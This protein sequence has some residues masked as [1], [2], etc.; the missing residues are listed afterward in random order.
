MLLLGLVSMVT[1][2]PGGVLLI[3]IGG[4][5]VIC[6]SERAENYM[7]IKRQNFTRLDSAMNWMEKKMGNRLSGPLRRT[8]P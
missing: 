5:M 1:P 4:G 3:T 7:R 2:I 8:R 6:N